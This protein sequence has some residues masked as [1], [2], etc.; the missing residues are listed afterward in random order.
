MA[1]KE[2]MVLIIIISLVAGAVAGAITVTVYEPAKT[3]EDYISEFYH[4]EV[5][6]HVSPHGLRKKMGKGDDTYVLV[7]LRSPQEYE[8]EH[9]VGAVSINAY[10]DPDHSAYDEVGRIIGG[11]ENIIEANPGK[12]IIV[13][14]YSIP[15]MTGR[16]IGKLLAD[17]GIYVQH[18]GVGWNEWKYFWNLWNHDG[19]TPVDPSLYVV[20]GNEP[21]S[22]EGVEGLDSGC[23][24]EGGF[25]C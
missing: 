8:T 20:S 3:E 4:T 2:S 17:N 16:K 5:A 13:Y 14:C 18:L 7:D 22:V 10:A 23:P 24:I 19:E 21:G 6:V 11:F 1:K 25:G 15:C 9:I 12:D